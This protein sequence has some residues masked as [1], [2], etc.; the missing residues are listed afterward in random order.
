MP[1]SFFP[2]DPDLPF[3]DDVE[4]FPLPDLPLPSEDAFVP[5]PDLPLP[6]EDDFPDPPFLAPAYF[7]LLPEFFVDFPADA[8]PLEDPPLVV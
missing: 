4:G 1:P 8:F 2:P 6:E 3:P 5:D 7:P